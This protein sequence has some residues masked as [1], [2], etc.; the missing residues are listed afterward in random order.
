MLY[1]KHDPAPDGGSVNQLFTPLD[2]FQN[3][4]SSFFWRDRK[5]SWTL[6]GFEHFCLQESRFNRQHVHA[7]T[8]KPVAESFEVCCQ[9]SFRRVV[10]RVS[11]AS[12]I[13]SDRPDADD[14]T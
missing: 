3:I 7:M 9:T 8:C 4:F 5:R 13:A 14:L 10:A 11:N 1:G 12:T 2:S 6:C